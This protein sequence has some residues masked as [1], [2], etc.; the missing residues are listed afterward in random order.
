MEE[1][2][3]DINQVLRNLRQRI[4]E[5]S[6]GEYSKGYIKALEGIEDEL[7]YY[8]PAEITEAFSQLLRKLYNIPKSAFHK[9]SDDPHEEIN[10]LLSSGI[11]VDP[12]NFRNIT[13][14]SRRDLMRK[15][16]NLYIAYLEDYLTQ[17]E[18]PTTIEYLKYNK[19]GGRSNLEKLCEKLI[20]KGF[21]SKIEPEE[22]GLVFS[23]KDIEIKNPINWEKHE[24]SFHHFLKNIFNNDNI[25]GYGP[26]DR[27]NWKTV[28]NCFRFK[29]KPVNIKSVQHNTNHPAQGDLLNEYV[30]FL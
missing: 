16:I 26:G 28:S 23:G 14:E 9:V 20:D 12:M 15:E 25:V 6:R 5:L 29:D 21:I 1:K 3:K 10:Y 7:Y 8:P 13:G 17:D 27:V 30:S 4:D 11:E 22:F 24:N 18:K 2:P 19:P